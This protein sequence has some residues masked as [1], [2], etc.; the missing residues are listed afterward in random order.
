LW[1]GDGG[2]GGDVIVHS[3]GLMDD[4]AG[5]VCMWPSEEVLFLFFLWTFCSHIILFAS[6]SAIRSL[7]RCMIPF[8]ALTVF[9]LSR[10]DVMKG[11]VVVELGAG[12]A[13]ERDVSPS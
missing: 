10:K 8:Q 11:C 12:V 5:N 9:L 13:V 1:G 2:G 7:C 6:S 3:Y 4:S